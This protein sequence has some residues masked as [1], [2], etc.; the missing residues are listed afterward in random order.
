MRQSCQPYE[1]FNIRG[2]ECVNCTARTLYE[3]GHFSLLIDSSIQGDCDFNGN[4]PNAAVPN[5]NN[6]GLYNAVNPKFRCTSS[7]DATTHFLIP[8]PVPVK[9]Q[10]VHL[11]QTD[12]NSPSNV[13]LRDQYSKGL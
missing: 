2:N 9:K 10:E 8:D 4:M 6:F 5:E 13:Y 12:I 7:Q 1:Y 3:K 11:T